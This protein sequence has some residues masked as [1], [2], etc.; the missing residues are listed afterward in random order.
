MQVSM[1]KWVILS[2]D[3]VNNGMLKLRANSK[4]YLKLIPNQYLFLMKD[5]KKMLKIVPL[6][7]MSTLM[8]NNMMFSYLKNTQPQV[9]LNGTLSVNNN[10]INSY[11]SI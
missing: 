6:R 8:V 11:S 7:L 9:G 5:L 3:M 10:L 2:M 1:V 4:R